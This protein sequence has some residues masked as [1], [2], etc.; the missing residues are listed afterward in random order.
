M[1][2]SDPIKSKKRFWSQLS[3]CEGK[4]IRASGL[5]DLISC[6]ISVLEKVKALFH[7]KRHKNLSRSCSKVKLHV[8]I[9]HLEKSYAAERIAFTYRSIQLK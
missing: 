3:I 4:Q 8:P 2:G 6:A 7:N 5:I 9:I 1:K